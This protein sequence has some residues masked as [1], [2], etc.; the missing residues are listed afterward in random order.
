MDAITASAGLP[1]PVHVLVASGL[2]DDTGGGVYRLQA[3]NIIPIDRVST[4]GLAVSSDGCLL[5]RLLW[6]QENAEVPGEIVM[7]HASETPTRRCSEALREPHGVMWHEDSFAAVSTNTNSI[8]WFNREGDIVRSWSAPG[9]GD[10]WHLNNLVVHDGRLLACAFGRFDEHRGWNRPGA[11]EGSG[12]VFD[13]ASGE[14]V[15]RGLTCPHDPVFLDDGWLV[16]NSATGELLRCDETGVIVERQP[17]GGW[18]RGLAYDE[19]R[20]YVG[21]SAHRL[22]GLQGTAM[23]AVC[24]RK[25]LQE[26]DRWTLPCREVFSLAFVPT[27]LVDALAAGLGTDDQLHALTES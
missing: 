15:L 5:A 9:E 3:G 12:V 17:I 23:V 8:L 14:D 21:V 25:T 16:C 1:E 13:L 22:L 4:T 24:D 20:V 19:T 6:N 26:V 2:G 11:C 18:T 10:C 27:Q 7:Y